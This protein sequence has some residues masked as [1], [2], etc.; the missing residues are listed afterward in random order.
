M[1]KYKY[2]YF[3][4]FYQKL[5][6]LNSYDDVIN[7]YNE[8][9]IGISD[10]VEKKLIDSFVCKDKY[11]KKL[12][13]NKFKICMETLMNIKHR[14]DAIE[15]QN[16]ILNLTEE[17]SQIN[18][19]KRLVMKICTNNQIINKQSN[20]IVIN[21]I[22]KNCPYCKKNLTDYTNRDYVICGYT[23]KGFD[24]EGCGHDWCFKCCKKLCKSWNIHE[25]FNKLNR[26]HNNRCCKLHAYKTDATYPDDYCNCGDNRY[27]NR[28]N[29]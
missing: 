24:W 8:S 5:F 3:N 20:T 7:L 2:K 10:E 9:V 27:V 14:S 15:I 21:K 6:R 26:Y 11:S 23:D 18:T 22:T 16:E 19:I 25:L 12:S 28:L 13:Y 29:T 17:K 4:E 1:D